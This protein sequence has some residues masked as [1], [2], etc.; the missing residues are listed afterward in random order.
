M[1]SKQPQKVERAIARLKSFHD[2]DIGL[3][4]VIA[5]GEQAIPALRTMLFERE[6]SGLYQARCRA[7]AA[8]AALGAHNVLI[9]F[10][11]A[12]RAIADPIERVGED[13]VINAAAQALANVH[14][15]RVF[16]LLLRL[17]H[18]PALT[19]AIG[20]LGAFANVEAIPLL[21]NALEEDA[22][23]L[24]AEAALRKLGRPACAALLRAV[25]TR[26]PSGERE[27]ES[28]VRRRRSA[29]RLLLETDRSRDAWRA[30]RHLVHDKD[31]KVAA[32]ACKICLARAPALERTDAVRCLI[33]LLAQQDWVLRE[34]IE[35]FLAA[36]FDRARQ[37]IAQYLNETPPPGEDAATRKQ[38]ETVLRRVMAR[39]QS[40]PHAQ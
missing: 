25:D 14:E 19:G 2:G 11:E 27:S 37:V 30:L 29:L 21:I 20:A 13:A 7:V 18:R 31:A 1:T 26:V 33:A 6:R 39:A 17:A 34:E 8:L 32:L 35:D 28:S 24:A 16:E 40:A 10:L 4:D 38:T 3:F 5:C 36:H 23:R 12:E 15:P 9:E 22:S